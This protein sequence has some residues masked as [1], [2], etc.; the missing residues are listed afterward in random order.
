MENENTCLVRFV[1]NNIA[2]VAYYNEDGS[3]IGFARIITIDSLP[4]KVK[5][6]AD[7][8][9][10][11]YDILCVQELVLQDKHLFYFNI[12]KDQCKKLIS[13]SVDGKVKKTSNCGK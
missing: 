6:V 12:V 7:S 5:L 11:G 10:T 13:I 3:A 8:L 2:Y 4:P 1:F 9:L